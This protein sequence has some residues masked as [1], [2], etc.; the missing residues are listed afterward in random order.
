MAEQ[1]LEGE[2]QRGW[3]IVLTAMIGIGLGLSPL[4]A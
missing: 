1:T 3:H 2:F 4:P